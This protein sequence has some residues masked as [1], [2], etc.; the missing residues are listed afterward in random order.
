MGPPTG[1]GEEA[2][3]GEQAPA[4]RRFPDRPLWFHAP[5]ACLQLCCG[6]ELRTPR[7]RIPRPMSDRASERGD[8]GRRSTRTTR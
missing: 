1:G 5:S 8:A 7:I 3:L 2:S 6:S 4:A